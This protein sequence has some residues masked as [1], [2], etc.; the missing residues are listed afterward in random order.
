MV[1]VELKQLSKSWSTVTS[2]DNL[3]LN[4]RDREFLVLLGPLAVE[5]VPL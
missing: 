5:K 3:N 1:S 4:I 2:V